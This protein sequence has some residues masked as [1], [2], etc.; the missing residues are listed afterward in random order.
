MNRI[1]VGFNASA[2]AHQALA[3]AVAL[4]ADCG[5]S[6]VVRTVV[7]APIADA[8][9]TA[10]DADWLERSKAVAKQE[11]DE[12]RRRPGRRGSG[13]VVVG[14]PVDELVELSGEVD[15]LVVGSRAWGPVRR[16]LIGSTAAKLM[17]KAQ[18]PVLVLP[19]GAAT[20]EPGEKDPAAARTEAPTAAYPR[21]DRPHA[22][23]A[24]PGERPRARRCR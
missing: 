9:L 6:L 8:D 17:R 7:A 2:E 4:A 23:G 18:C 10:Y 24:A 5:A 14:T 12:A 3:L 19:R 11:L 1:G 15:L 21:G 13:D 16:T 22:S 20:G